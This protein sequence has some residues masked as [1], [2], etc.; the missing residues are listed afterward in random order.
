MDQQIAEPMVTVRKR[1]FCNLCR[2]RCGAVYVTE[3]D[4][5]VRVEPDTQHP[6]GHALCPKGRAAPEML[7]EPTR[8]LKPLRRTAPKGA[9]DPGFEE[10]S[11][12]DALA[13]VAERLAAVRAESGAEAVAFEVTT[14]SG[15][16]ISDSIDWIER[17]IRV[18]GSPNT[19][20]ATEICNW[21]K[22]FAHAFTFGMAR[23][24]PD[25]AHCDVAVLWGFNPSNTWLALASRLAAAQRRGAR[26]VVVDPQPTGYARSADVWA[27]LRPGSDL[28]LALGLIRA[29]LERGRYDEAFVRRWTN[30]AL[31]V[32]ETGALIETRAADGTPRHLVWDQGAGVAAL[33]D[34]ATRLMPVEADRLALSGTM[35]VTVDGRTIAARPVFATLRE[36]V[37]PYGL[38]RTAA[39]T[40]LAEATIEALA[41]I[42]DAGTAV[43]LYAWT[44]V[45]QHQAA[46]QTE[47]AI[48]ILEALSGAV[49]RPGTGVVVPAVPRNGVASHDILPPEQ[50]AKALGLA[51]RPIGPARQGYVNAADF[52]RAA[53]EGDPY[54]VR[55]LVAFGGNM[56]ASQP[57]PER[58]AAALE[59]LDFHVH[60]DHR[61]TP[62]A[63]YA[64]IVLPATLPWEHEALKLG[65][66]LDAA[67]QGLVQLRPRMVPPR[68]EAR[69]DTDIV[70]DLATRLGHADDFFGGRVEAGWAHIL[71]PSG[72]TLTALRASPEGIAVPLEQRYE[73]YAA[74]TDGRAAGFATPTGLVEIHS[75]TLA[76]HGYPPLPAGDASP[77]GLTLTTAKDGLYCHSQHRDIPSLR[78]R[79]P[80]PRVRLHPDLAD[81]HAIDVDDWVLVETAAGQA[82]FRARLDAQADPTTLVA[83]YGWWQ[84]NVRLGLAALPVKGEGTSNYNALVDGHLTDPLSGSVALR[85]VPATI[86][87]DRV[88]NAPARAFAGTRPFRVVAVHAETPT[89]RTITLAPEDGEPIPDY[90]PGQHL[91]VV[92]DREGTALKRAYSISGG[93]GGLTISVKAMAAPAGL[94]VPAGEMSNHL[95]R[96]VAAG[97]VL[98]ATAPKGRFLLGAGEG[99]TVLIANGVGITPFVPFLKRLAPEGPPVA[100]VYGVAGAAE[101]AFAAEIAAAAVSNA[102]LRVHTY[103]SRETSPPEGV[104]CGRLS[105][106]GLEDFVTDPACRF[107]LCGAS[108]MI[109]AVAGDLERLGVRPSRIEWEAFTAPAMRPAVRPDRPFAITLGAHQFA[110]TPD[111]R[112]LLDAAERQG[113]PISAGCRTG[114]CESCAKTLLS[115]KVFDATSGVVDGV[116]EIL[117]CQVVPI[118][119]VRL[120]D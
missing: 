79:S 68:G 112:T 22:D 35:T 13:T 2:S 97:S 67:A 3:G 111:D 84:E 45:G 101:H 73:K 83:D 107:Y 18:F 48:S 9:E 54:R 39:E 19:V 34:P 27:R 28:A 43:G 71:A 117:T 115:G 94:S 33:Y 52:S 20:Y 93:E 95:H 90:L 108:E 42:F 82:R 38:A 46:T 96:A 63:R 30:A 118:S 47:R 85:G 32:D 25:F 100:L 66:E 21:H 72:I 16:G 110:W 62:T 102:R 37:A 53:I 113:A 51:E 104:A 14:P 114:Q 40:G 58:S 6:T 98:H 81:R 119:D 23:P 5:L 87:R 44:G 1:G 56:M 24:A 76:R 7:S 103:Y 49:D 78:R 50:Q 36:A 57:N 92:L 120:A 60:V 65:F 8:L 15:T 91:E 99:P 74:E 116:A 17:F 4:R 105:L 64:D 26:L 106:A 55:A 59:A 70:F 89:I 86:T 88:G 31:L 41:E 29:V 80:E 77:A 75:V 69:S 12:D 11:W 61:M 109:R 10:I